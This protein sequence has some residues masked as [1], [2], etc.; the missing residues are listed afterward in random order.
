MSFYPG[1]RVKFKSLTSESHTFR[2]NV[3]RELK[4][5]R[6]LVDDHPRLPPR[7]VRAERL[8]L[9]CVTHKGRAA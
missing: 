3:V 9:D 4:F 7:A 6:V 2:G 1:Q 8:E 5:D